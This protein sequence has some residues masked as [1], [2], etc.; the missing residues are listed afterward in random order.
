MVLAESESG[1]SF[2]LPFL[3][4]LWKE[5]VYVSVSMVSGVCVCVCLF[6]MCMCV[7]CMCVM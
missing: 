1:K 6:V 2:V 4:E 5:G 7:V 3:R